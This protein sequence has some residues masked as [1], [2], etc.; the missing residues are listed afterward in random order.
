MITEVL[1]KCKAYEGVHD[2]KNIEGNPA[3][4]FDQFRVW[5]DLNTYIRTIVINGISPLSWALKEEKITGQC[6]WYI[7]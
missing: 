1:E 6:K 5:L 7:N 2:W 4:N 3:M